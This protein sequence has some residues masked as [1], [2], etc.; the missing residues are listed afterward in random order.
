LKRVRLRGVAN[1]VLPGGAVVETNLQRRRPAR[2]LAL[3]V[4]E[5]RRGR[6][7]ERGL[8]SRVAGSGGAAAAAAPGRDLRERAF[9]RRLLAPP[10]ATRA[11]EGTRVSVMRVC[12]WWTASPRVKT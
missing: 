1:R 12:D 8:F 10:A 6:D 4:L 7:D 2:E 3:P 11:V 9:R 5:Q